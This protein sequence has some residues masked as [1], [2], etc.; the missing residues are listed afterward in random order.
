MSKKA[1]GIRFLGLSY[2]QLGTKKRTLLNQCPQNVRFLKLTRG[3][4]CC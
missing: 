4:N 1:E 2:G 3:V